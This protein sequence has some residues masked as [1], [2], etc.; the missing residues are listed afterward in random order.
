LIAGA[1]GQ[2]N[3]NSIV[4]PSPALLASDPVPLS[5]NL[6]PNQNLQNPSLNPDADQYQNANANPSP[7]DASNTGQPDGNEEDLA[8]RGWGGGGWGRPGW[9]RPGWGGG[10]GRP[11]WGGGWGRPCCGWG[12]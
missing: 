3:S 7:A 6:S 2:S 4:E 8:S 10:W 5:Y 12:K 1:F 9:G 11:G